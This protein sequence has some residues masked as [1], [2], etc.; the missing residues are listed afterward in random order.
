M[1]LGPSTPVVHGVSQCTPRSGLFF[2]YWFLTPYVR[3]TLVFLVD[4]G[5]RVL[6]E[7]TF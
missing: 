5:P 6:P 3:E 4:G 7:Q 2:T 1:Y